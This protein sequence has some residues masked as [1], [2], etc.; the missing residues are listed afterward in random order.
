MYSALD[1]AKYI[2]DYCYRMCKPISNLK[3]QKMLYFMWIDYYNKY[4]KLLFKEHFQAYKFGPMV[5]EVYYEFCS[6]AGVELRKNF[7]NIFKEET[8]EDIENII[9]IQDL[10]DKYIDVSVYEIVLKSTAKNGAW[11]IIYNN[12]EGSK[13]EIPFHLIRKLSKNIEE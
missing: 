5:P 8:A 9:I 11:D 4:N 1:L 10:I 12:G 3:L 13:N 7:E 6:Y 2:V